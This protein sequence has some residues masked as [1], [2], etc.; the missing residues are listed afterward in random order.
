MG[1]PRK[2]C[3]NRKQEHLNRVLFFM[4]KVREEEREWEI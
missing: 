2:C 1:P 4:V 3:K